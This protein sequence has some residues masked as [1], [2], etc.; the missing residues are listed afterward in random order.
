MISRSAA[1]LVL[2]VAVEALWPCAAQD[3]YAR[4]NNYT[5]PASVF[6]TKD[7]VEGDDDQAVGKIYQQNIGSFGF[8]TKP[9]GVFEWAVVGGSIA[10][11]G[12]LALCCLNGMGSLF[13]ALLFACGWALALYG[14]AFWLWWGRT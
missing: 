8:F 4:L 9:F 1:T 6:V 14:D 13:G 2:C 5:E 12:L 11:L 10:V 3:G 7:I